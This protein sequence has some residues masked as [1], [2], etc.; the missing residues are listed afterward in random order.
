MNKQA[1]LIICLCVIYYATTSRD[2]SCDHVRYHHMKK[3]FSAAEWD[4]VMNNQAT[5]IHME[6]NIITITAKLSSKKLQI[7]MRCASQ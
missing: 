3:M 7:S 1:I 2:E 4:Y 6:D 5:A